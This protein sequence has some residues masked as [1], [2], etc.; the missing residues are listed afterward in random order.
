ML[1]ERD[2]N[3]ATEEELD[4]L[5]NNFIERSSHQTGEMPIETFFELL[6]ENERKRG[7]Q[8]IPVTLSI[9]DGQVEFNL[10]PNRETTILTRN[11]EIFVGD[12]LLVVG[13]QNGNQ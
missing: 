11:N 4:E 5:I 2:L 6:F 9:K 3:E 8:T 13:L 12:T 10:P 7:E 1:L